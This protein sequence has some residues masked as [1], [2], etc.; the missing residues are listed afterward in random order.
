MV[1]PVEIGAQHS[2][3]ALGTLIT[4]IICMVLEELLLRGQYDD[5]C[6]RSNKSVNAKRLIYNN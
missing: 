1:T 6:R 2:V 3:V 5:I 4:H